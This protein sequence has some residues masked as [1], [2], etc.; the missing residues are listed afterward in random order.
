[1][2]KLKYIKKKQAKRIKKLEI[3]CSMKITNIFLKNT[4]IKIKKKSK[5]IIIT[6]KLKKL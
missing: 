1:M 6:K 4:I 2:I 3:N 5:K